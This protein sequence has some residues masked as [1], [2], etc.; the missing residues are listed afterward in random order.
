M[1]SAGGAGTAGTVTVVQTGTIITTGEGSHGIIA[2]SAAGVEKR[3]APDGTVS[4]PSDLTNPGPIVQANAGAV[5]VTVNGSINASGKNADGIVAQSLGGTSNGNITINITTTGTVSGGTDDGAAVRIL[6]GNNNTL[7]SHGTL[8]TQ[9]GLAGVTVIGGAGND[10]FENYGRL[11]GLVNL[12]GG[13]NHFNNHAGAEVISGDTI[14]IGAT[15]TFDNFGHFSPGG[16]N[17]VQTT[18]LTGSFAQHAGGSFDFDLDLADMSYDH[19]DV[20]GTATMA[21][22]MTINYV[23]P[24]S[25]KSGDYLLNFLT[26]TGGVTDNGMTL[27]YAPSAVI[28][29]SLLYPDAN[30]ASLGVSVNFAPP[31][32]ADLDPNDFSIGNYLNELQSTGSSP[33]LEPLMTKIF[34]IGSAEELA[35]FYKTLSPESYNATGLSNAAAGQILATSM[36]SCRVYNGGSFRFTDEGECN[37]AMATPRTTK[38]DHTG[39]NMGSQTD[40]IEFAFGQQRAISDHYRLGFGLSYTSTNTQVEDYA[41]SSGDRFQAGLVGKMAYDPVLVALAFTGGYSSIDSDRYVKFPSIFTTASSTQNSMSFGTRLRVA[42][43]LFG[44]NSFY[45]RPMVDLN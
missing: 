30:N 31:A 41:R 19:L 14:D 25:A 45:V 6:D 13:I 5:S 20:S 28:T 35:E 15:N 40:D 23:H 37:W 24:G 27:T 18:A 8:T 1:G 2:Q 10:T 36:L 11:Y 17:N 3:V 33:A 43:Q 44:N 29:Y 38:L 26:A 34:T 21:G 7:T 4:D 32:G 22:T 9:K 39:S 16:I 12:G 42:T